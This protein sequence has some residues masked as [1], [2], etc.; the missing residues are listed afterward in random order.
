MSISSNRL[1]ELVEE[2][3]GQGRSKHIFGKHAPELF[4]VLSKEE[5]S[6]TETEFAEGLKKCDFKEPEHVGLISF[7][8]PPLC[9]Y[10]TDRIMGKTMKE[11]Y[12]FTLYPEINRSLTF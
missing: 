11:L 4:E 7:L 10:I 5:S 8:C 9:T 2:R 1:K 3:I 6:L 12:K